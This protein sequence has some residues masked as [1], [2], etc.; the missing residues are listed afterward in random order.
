MLV[1]LGIIA[2]FAGVG[3]NILRNEEITRVSRLM[4]VPVRVA[5]TV[6]RCDRPRPTRKVPSY[7]LSPV[8]PQLK[9]SYKDAV[10]Q[11]QAGIQDG[12]EAKF[13]ASWATANA[14]ANFQN[15]S[16]GTFPNYGVRNPKPWGGD[17]YVSHLKHPAC[18]AQMTETW[19]DS[20]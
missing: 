10:A 8:F 9:S 7:Y 2:I 19:R 6:V 15:G 1:L 4:L 14:A 18:G 17:A 13:H 20:A 5:C 3:F 12:V 16:F 11:I